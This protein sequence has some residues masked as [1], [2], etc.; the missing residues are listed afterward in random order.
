[1]AQAGKPSTA[2]WDDVPSQPG[3]VTTNYNQWYSSS[4]APWWAAHCGRFWSGV[5]RNFV[6]IHS[7]PHFSGVLCCTE[8]KV[9]MRSSLLYEE[10]YICII[11]SS[12][13]YCYKC[14]KL[15]FSHFC[16]AVSLL[17]HFLCVGFV[18][19]LL[20]Y[21]L[22]IWCVIKKK[23]NNTKKYLHSLHSCVLY[24]FYFSKSFSWVHKKIQIFL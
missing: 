21:Y 24:S 7:T 20:P 19:I 5:W 17:F 2:V 15:I 9:E 12:H 22:T 13:Y 23:H 10:L 14:L 18:L 11:H 1:M 8:Y 16:P 6:I 3:I 4:I